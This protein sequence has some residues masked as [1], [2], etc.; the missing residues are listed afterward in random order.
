[1]A[2]APTV[3]VRKALAGDVRRIARIHRDSWRTAYAGILRRAD[4]DALTLWRLTR[5]WRRSLRGVAVA[6]VDGR[7]QGF[8]LIGPSRDPDMAGFGGEIFMLYVHPSAQGQGVGR[9]LL[10]AAAATLARRGHRWL[11]LWVLA[12]NTAAQG[13]YHRM[14]L[15]RDGRTRL[16]RHSLGTPRVLR[17]A[18]SLQPVDGLLTD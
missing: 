17:Y 11:V 15:Q 5:R 3:H 10:T 7:I 6:E 18:Q 13:F 9:A 2:T 14:G 12:E 1:M 16:D 4:L 8:V